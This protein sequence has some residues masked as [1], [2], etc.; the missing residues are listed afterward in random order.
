MSSHALTDNPWLPRA[1]C[2]SSCIRPDGSHT[3]HP[4]VVA[5]R[6]ST[7]IFCALMLF[8]ALPLLAVPLPGRSKIQRIYCRMMLRCIGVRALAATLGSKPSRLP[9]VLRLMRPS[10]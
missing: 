3:S 9:A 8:P 10:S 2:D 4:A 1:S 7:R 5:L 6:T